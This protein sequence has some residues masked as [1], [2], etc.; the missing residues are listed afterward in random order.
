MQELVA[1]EIIMPTS[2]PGGFVKRGRRDGTRRRRAAGEY[3]AKTPGCHVKET[4]HVSGAAQPLTWKLMVLQMLRLMP[5][6]AYIRFVPTHLR[7]RYHLRRQLAALV[8]ATT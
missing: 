2:K 7:S 1:P 3:H 5:L 4:A 8:F 6:V